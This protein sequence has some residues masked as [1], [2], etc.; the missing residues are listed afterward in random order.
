MTSDGMV[1]LDDVADLDVGYAFKSADFTADSSGSRLLRGDNIGQGVTRWE[2]TAYWPQAE[3][4]QS[5][6]ELREADVVLAMDRPWIEAGLKY[7]TISAPD[8]PALLV[9]R[10]ARLRAKPGTDQGYL[11][12]VIGSRGFTEFV[13][14]VQTGTSI[15]HISGKQIA[16]YRLRLHSLSEQRAIAEVLG[17]LDDKISA[18][19]K[20]VDLLVQHQIAEYEISLRRGFESQPLD[21]VADFHNRKRVPLS[22]KERDERPGSIPYYGATGVFGSVDQ[23]LFNDNLVLVGEDGS[24]ITPGGLPVI[25]YI[26]G[27]SW[28]NNHAHVLT[29]RSVSTELLRFALSPNRGN[30]RAR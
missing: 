9:Q 30:T 4:A 11:G 7:A 15:P 12:C 6:Y 29:G 26:W 13:L 24:V 18:N 8:L 21:K 3:L 5:R 17:A 23:S 14:A 16:G 20:T 10:V 27:P 25:Q 1:R 28:V 19:V 22:A 2:R